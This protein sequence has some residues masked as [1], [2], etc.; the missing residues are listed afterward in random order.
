MS[1]THA[2][3]PRYKATLIAAFLSVMVAQAGFAMPGA[4]NGTFQT[5]FKTQGSQLT[6]I[7]AAFAIPMVIFEL[8]A[9]VL[10]D[11]FGR[12]RLL[13]AGT[14][15]TVVGAVTIFFAQGVYAM[16]VGQV[17]AG[18]GAAVLFPTSL[19]VVASAAPSTHER[20]RVIAIWA[21]FLSVGAVVSP[22]LSGVF[23]KYAS[24]R[25]GYLVIIVVAL[26]ALSANIFAQ[27]SS[28][29]EGRK[30]DL[31][32]QMTLAVG[33]FAIMYGL[34]QGAATGWKTDIIIAFVIGAIL[35]VS[36]IVIELR[37]ESPLLRLSLFR[38]RPFAIAGVTATIGMFSF[39]AICFSLSV[40]LGAV[41]HQ[42]ALRIGIIFV[43][44]QGPAFL[45]SPAVARMIRNISPRWTLAA[46]Y[47]LFGI[48][49]FWLSGF[50]VHD[51]SW[52]RWFLPMLV[53]GLGF[54]L[55]VGSLTAVA[56][57]SVPLKFAGMASATTNMLRD[58]GIALGPVIIGA[59]TVNIA[60]G[61]LTKG[62]GSA[63][64]GVQQ[65]YA[66]IAGDISHKAGALA[67][68]SIPV[69]PGATAKSA[70]LPMPAGLHELALNSLGSAYSV[71]F[72]IGAIC[73][74]VACVVVLIGLRGVQ[75]VGAD[76][77]LES[78]LNLFEGIAIP[79]GGQPTVV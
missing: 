21:G 70:S 29:P 20:T 74:L 1:E 7:T 27:E 22:L 24:W 68:N 67:I 59:V 79:T 61:K 32:G 12:R 71:G 30:L 28:A 38:S 72:R 35:L 16:W 8:T 42:T 34:V 9:G 11:L 10:G 25:E 13:F 6:W 49:G 5:V 66:T 52:T 41:Q 31:P 65:P 55:T 36:F 4:L 56:I 76:Q 53:I 64:S 37:T 40:F 62:L 14:S 73:G 15:L 18:L 26:A 47:L 44:I 51:M 60:N 3:M 46:G 54:A 77:K 48:G 57:H 2:H 58:L 33:L 45:L 63:L 23:V 78:E 43:F 39:L 19:A 69:I 50:G 17:F 75:P